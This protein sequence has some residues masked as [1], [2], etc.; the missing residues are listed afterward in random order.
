MLMPSSRLQKHSFQV[1]STRPRQRRQSQG[2]CATLRR[3]RPPRRFWTMLTRTLRKLLQES[4]VRVVH[5]LPRP[6]RSC[7][8]LPAR[9]GA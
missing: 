6:R 9:R 8:Q 4:F 1:R 3:Q 7:S 2:L 5:P